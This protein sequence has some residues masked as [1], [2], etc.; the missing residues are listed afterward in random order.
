MELIRAVDL[1][2]ADKNQFIRSGSG[3][4][5]LTHDHKFL[6]QQRGQDWHSFPGKLSTFGGCMDAGETPLQTLQR[7]LNE[8]L[9]AIVTYAVFLGA[10]TEKA[11][12]Y[13]E[14]CHGFFWHDKA[15]TIT[16]CYEGAPVYFATPEEALSQPNLMD[17]VRWLLGECRDKSLI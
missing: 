1:S 8:E 13:T 12:N 9:G 10:Y 2:S 15:G 11:T 7:E 5:I 4:I 14:L 16:G 17:D 6:L 3:A